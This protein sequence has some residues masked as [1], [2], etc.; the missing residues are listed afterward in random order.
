VL[1]LWVTRSQRQF[2]W[3]TEILNEVEEEDKRGLIR[4]HIFITQFKNKFDLRT[5]FL[6]L[7]E[8][9]FQ[10]VSSTSMFTGLKAITHFSRPS[11]PD[12]FR[13]VKEQYNFVSLAL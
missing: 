5:V 1:F 4:N 13:A 7:A 11:F 2:E 6:Y 8:R 9:H 10:R 3:L 12:I